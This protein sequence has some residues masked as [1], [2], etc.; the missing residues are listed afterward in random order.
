MSEPIRESTAKIA[1]LEKRLDKIELAISR[2]AEWLVV[3]AVIGKDD[4]ADL[5][6][7]FLKE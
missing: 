4:L 1:E 6:P 2:I 7:G 3:T 5:P